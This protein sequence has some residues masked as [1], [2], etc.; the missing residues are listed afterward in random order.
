MVHFNQLKLCAP[1]TSL[2]QDG[3]TVL[4]HSDED[5]NHSS[6]YLTPSKLIVDI[7]LID[8]GDQL[9]ADELHET[10]RSCYPSHA[11][12]YPDQF[13]PGVA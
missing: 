5:Q 9:V 1:D 4:K 8:Y 11:R 12:H 3:P 13:V 2:E 10:A 6:S 7:E